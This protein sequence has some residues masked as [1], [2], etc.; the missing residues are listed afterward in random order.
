MAHGAEAFGVVA[1]FGE[2]GGPAEEGSGVEQGVDAALED[3]GGLVGRCVAQPAHKIFGLSGGH[4]GG[5]GEQE[6][7][8][9]DEAFIFRAILLG[10]FDYGCGYGG[11]CGGAGNALASTEKDR[12]GGIFAADEH[13]VVEKF[14]GQEEVGEAKRAVGVEHVG[15]DAAENVGT[16]QAVEH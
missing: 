7:Q 6:G 13:G 1:P 4:P 14:F 16:C 2:A 8:R 10:V 15:V 5:V 11:L 9:A 12:E 3:D